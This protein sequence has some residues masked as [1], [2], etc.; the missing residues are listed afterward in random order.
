[1]IFLSCLRWRLRGRGLTWLRVWGEERWGEV[2]DGE[3]NLVCD[4]LVWKFKGTVM[5]NQWLHSMNIEPPFKNIP[6]F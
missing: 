4:W 1:M 6:S 3:L 5:W 2:E